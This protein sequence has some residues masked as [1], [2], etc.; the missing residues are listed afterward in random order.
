MRTNDL[1]RLM[2]PGDEL[3]PSPRKIV[4]HSI[5]IDASPDHIWPWLIQL[6]SGRAGWYSYDRIDN[7]GTPSAGRIIPEFQ[8]VEAG[9]ILPAIPNTKDAFIVREI[10]KGK[11]IVLVVPI[12][13]AEEVA[14]P[15]RRM[16]SALRLSWALVLE[17]LPDQR[18]TLLISRGR[19]SSDWLTTSPKNKD[20]AKRPIFIERMYGLMS[21]M[22]WFLLLP[23]AL[24]GHYFMES[25]M[26]LGI[27]RRAESL[28]KITQTHHSFI[29]KKSE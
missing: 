1:N 16:K 26:L 23:I 13:T 10:Q 18:Q 25:R 9:D 19:I 21:G 4:T 5:I 8:H 22:P 28:D 27:K 14:D 11:A 20:S 15:K 12:S 7:G 29:T 2:L 3:I 24:T 17:P 6:G